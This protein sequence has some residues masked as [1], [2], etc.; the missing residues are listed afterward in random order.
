M[1]RKHIEEE[2]YHAL[3]ESDTL[4]DYFCLVGLD[5]QRILQIVKEKLSRE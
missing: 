1:E 3:E 2:F 4:V 5:Q